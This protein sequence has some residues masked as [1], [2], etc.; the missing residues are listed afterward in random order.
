MNNTY[1]KKPLSDDELR[2]KVALLRKVQ[3]VT[4]PIGWILFCSIFVLTFLCCWNPFWGNQLQ[5]GIDIFVFFIPIISFAIGYTLLHVSY[6]RCP[7]KIWAVVADSLLPDLLRE[8]FTYLTYD[9]KGSVDRKLVDYVDMVDKG[10]LLRVFA[11][12]FKGRNHF[13]GLY[14]GRKVEFSDIWIYNTNP[15][16]LPG[17]GSPA[18]FFKGPWMTFDHGM[19]VPTR[20]RIRERTR[21][22]AD[23][24]KTISNVITPDAEFNAR[25][26][27]VADNPHLAYLILT[28]QFIKRVMKFGGNVRMCFEPG[29]AHIAFNTDRYTF[30]VTGEEWEMADLNRLRKRFRQEIQH[31]TEVI[32]IICEGDRI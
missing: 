23:A 22:F 9:S 26:Q 29:R 24:K 4:R 17:A 3:K 2:E 16:H 20:I 11:A 6:G 18:T 31:I 27:V 10:G 30:E 8:K 14:K 7:N 12:A 13:L 25:F 5:T 28:P 32:D 1:I 19:Y 15:S 21:D